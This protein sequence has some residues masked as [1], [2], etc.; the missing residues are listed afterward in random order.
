MRSGPFD[1]PRKGGARGFGRVGLLGRRPAPRARSAASW[2]SSSHEERSCAG[3]GSRSPG[4]LLPR[5]AARWPPPARAGSAARAA[6]LSARPIAWKRPTSAR[7]RPA[8]GTPRTNC[9]RHGPRPSTVARMRAASAWCGRL[10]P[11]TTDGWLCSDPHPSFIARASIAAG[12][13][14]GGCSKAPTARLRTPRRSARGRH[15]ARW[16]VFSRVAS[17]ASGSP[18]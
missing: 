10:R 17:R 3:A 9:L 8:I 6:R 13:R 11:T 16:A 15:R 7:V 12:R 2:Q 1:V 4:S 14:L 18:C 5:P